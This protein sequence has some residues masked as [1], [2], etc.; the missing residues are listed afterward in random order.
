MNHYQVVYFRT[1]SKL[2][3]W[4]QPLY[5]GIR[6]IVRIIDPYHFH[7]FSAKPLSGWFSRVYIFMQVNN[8]FYCRQYVFR[9]KMSTLH[10]L[11]DITELIRSNTQLDVSCMLLDLRNIY[12]TINHGT[13]FFKLE[14]YGVRGICLEWLSLFLCFSLIVPNELPKLIG[15]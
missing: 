9:S 14:S 8:L 1:F 5:L 13:F 11:T 2:R 6:A 3:K 10:A 7:W 12:N 4:F 15:I